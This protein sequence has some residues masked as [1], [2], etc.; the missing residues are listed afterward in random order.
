LSENPASVLFANSVQLSLTEELLLQFKEKV[1]SLKQMKDSA[2]KL[3]NEAEI[4]P[5]KD[6]LS[7]LEQELKDLRVEI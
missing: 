6:L 3:L 1:N 2:L 5:S 4:E 7:D